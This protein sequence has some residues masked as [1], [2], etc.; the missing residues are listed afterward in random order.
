MEIEDIDI[1][2]FNRVMI[3]NLIVYDQNNEVILHTNKFS[4]RISLYE[5]IRGNISVRTMLLMDSD[6]RLYQNSPELPAN[7]QYLVD[8]FKNP[9][10]QT[11]SSKFNISSLNCTVLYY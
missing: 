6:I 10:E 2:L 11:E 8:L 9:D 7:Y 5:L 3:K 1:G 4:A